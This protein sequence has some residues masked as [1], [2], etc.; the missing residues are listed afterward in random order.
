[1]LKRILDL[2]GCDNSIRLK[3][4]EKFIAWIKKIEIANDEKILSFYVSGEKINLI[5]DKSIFG[6]SFES[7]ELWCMSSTM[8]HKL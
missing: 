1:M 2:F 3:D 6:F 8:L 5:T 7:G 4:N